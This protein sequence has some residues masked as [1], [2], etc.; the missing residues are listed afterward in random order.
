MVSTPRICSGPISSTSSMPA[1][2]KLRIRSGS[3]WRKRRKSRRPEVPGENSA[4]SSPD[5]VLALGDLGA[6]RR[7]DVEDRPVVGDLR[8]QRRAV[9]LGRHR[10][11]AAVAVHRAFD[12]RR[13]GCGRTTLERVARGDACGGR[14]GG[15]CRRGL[16]DGLRIEARIGGGSRSGARA[17][18][19]R[20]AR[21]GQDGRA[22]QNL[23]THQYFRSC[24]CH[25]VIRTGAQSRDGPP[26]RQ[27]TSVWRM[28]FSSS[29]SG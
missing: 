10:H 18:P 3:A 11:A 4:M 20:A 2:T 24:G 25:L 17:A 14:G 5:P 27:V 22:D 13:I 19:H 16:D 26:S 8:R 29:R 1:V 15:L 7:L 21:G 12:G 28:K 9:R 23:P 6:G